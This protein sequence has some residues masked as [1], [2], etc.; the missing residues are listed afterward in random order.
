MCAD[1]QEMLNIASYL[2]LYNIFVSA[3]ES[4]INFI[5]NEEKMRGL[6]KEI[7]H[8]FPNDKVDFQNVRGQDCYTVAVFQEHTETL[9]MS[10]R[11]KLM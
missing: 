4:S 1:L 3:A 8:R 11:K 5:K 7:K 6:A 9:N 10:I 2:N